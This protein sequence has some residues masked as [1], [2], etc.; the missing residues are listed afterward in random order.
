MPTPSPSI[1]PTR[2]AA[3][4]IGIWPE[5]SP[6]VLVPT[7]RLIRATPRGRLIATSEPNARTSTT[8]ATPMP[9]S[10]LFGSA[11]ASAA[12]NRPLYS[13]VSPAARIGAT[14]SSAS[15]RGISSMSLVSKVTVA[16]PIRPSGLS[17]GDAASYGSLTATTCGSVAISLEGRG[18]H[19]AGL[20][21][22]RVRRV[23]A[24]DHLAGVRVLRRELLLEEVDGPLGLGPRQ[25]ELVVGL[26]SELRVQGEGRTRDDEPHSDDSPRVPAGELPESE[27][28]G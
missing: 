3:V 19:R 20:G 23:V 6:M 15:S 4:G 12:P 28:D 25:P 10:S 16:K 9:I 26:P 14:A 22:G 1:D 24:E 8:T 27:Q 11:G 2:V 21:S 17:M 13:T 5:I 7:R 18:D